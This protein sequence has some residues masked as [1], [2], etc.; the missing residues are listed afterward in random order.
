M[1]SLCLR[2]LSF[3]PPSVLSHP[4]VHLSSSMQ[5][6]WTTLISD[7][8]PWCLGPRLTVSISGVACSK[9]SEA[10][11]PICPAHLFVL[12]VRGQLCITSLSVRDRP[13]AL[14]AVTRWYV[15]VGSNVL[16]WGKKLNAAWRVTWKQE[17]K[18]ES[19]LVVPEKEWWGR[20]G[21]WLF[22]FRGKNQREVD[23]SS[24]TWAKSGGLTKPLGHLS[25][26]ST[27]YL[28]SRER[29]GPKKD[30]IFF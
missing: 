27:P 22:P 30:V 20:A 10:R 13:L 21:Y 15:P 8:I 9:V 16:Y 26:V 1:P 2:L 25:H 3:L 5:P 28:C 7:E 19:Q 4:S 24:I 18:P 23:H 29:E 11:N 14:K 6:L 17:Y 12:G